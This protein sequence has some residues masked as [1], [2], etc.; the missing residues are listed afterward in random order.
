MFSCEA[1]LDQLE[2]YSRRT[3]LRFFGIPE[4]EK[5]IVNFAKADMRDV[6]IR[7]RRRLRESGVGPTVYVNEDLTRRRVAL[8][9]KTRQLKKSR[10][11]ND[12]WTF[13][14]K[15]VVKTID[16]VVNR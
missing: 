8:A 10:N 5:V 14:G 12:C 2:Q 9:K 16:G 11:I 1:D 4:S 13:N 3:N 6:G 7:A 15:V